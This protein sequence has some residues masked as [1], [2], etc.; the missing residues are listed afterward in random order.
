MKKVVFFVG[1]LILAIVSVNDSNHYYFTKAKN[2]Q[3]V[4]FEKEY[5]DYFEKNSEKSIIEGI[6][7]LVIPEKEPSR[8]MIV[9][10]PDD[11][12][13]W[14]GSHLLK[15][16]YTVVC[17]TCGT[18]DYR[19]E[20]FKRVMEITEDDYMMLGF[21]DVTNGRI[22]S[23]NSVYDEIYHTLKDIID[24]NDWDMI[25]THNP[26]GEYG[27]IHHKMTSTMVTDLSNKNKLYYFGKYYSANDINYMNIL[28][29]EETL[30]DR[31]MNE[32]IPVYQSQP[33]AMQTHHHMMNHENWLN[34]Y[35]WS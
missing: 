15:N 10:H 26:E 1:F 29:V 5:I 4:L 25:I 32:L 23:W 3:S 12:T 14:G 24:S 9:A 22:D 34:Y 19:V 18:V 6:E 16:K 28:T 11:E 35:E 17:I 2:N 21:P 31:K 7:D 20:E 33:I 30:Y 13:I 27:H 8:L